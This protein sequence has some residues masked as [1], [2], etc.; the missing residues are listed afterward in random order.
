MPDA[1]FV[2]GG[3]L[4]PGDAIEM[5]FVRASGPG[6]QNVNKVASKAVLRVDLA[7]IRGIDAPGRHRL[8]RIVSRRL[9]S[10]GRLMVYSQRSRDQFRNLADAR[11]KI[12]DW[13]AQALRPPKKRVSVRL[14]ESLR[15]RRLEEKR[16][17]SV[18]KAGRRR[19]A[20]ETDETP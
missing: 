5:K 18:R 4:V 16:Q 1:I 13:I 17:L 3:V 19:V 12:H 2:E 20:V 8:L 11:K 6:G 10:A 9:D 7:R 14:N 15:E